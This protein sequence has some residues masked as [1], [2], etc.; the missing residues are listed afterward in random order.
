MRTVTTDVAK[1]A[2]T[3][4]NPT[5]NL[6]GLQTFSSTLSDGREVVVREMTGRDLLYLEEELSG[7]G[8]SRTIY[9]LLERLNVGSVTLTF[10]EI[11][12]L[13]VKDIKKLSALVSKANGTD[14]DQ[15]GED[16]K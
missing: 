10:D 4:T 3:T 15:D 8:E 2:A 12:D 1:P 6:A 11:A 7:K 13:P 14:N 16:P 9:H 5:P